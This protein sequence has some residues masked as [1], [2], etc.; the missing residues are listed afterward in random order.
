MNAV[1]FQ[2]RVHGLLRHLRQL[3]SVRHLD[4]DSTLVLLLQDDVR[5]LLVEPDTEAFKLAFDD[6]LVSQ[7]LL[8]VKHDQNE[9]A[10]ARH[11]DDLLTSTLAIFGSLDN[12]WQIE[13]LDLGA[14]IVE[15][16]WDAGQCCEFISGSLRVLSGQRCQESRL[17]YGREAYQ[18]VRHA[19]LQWT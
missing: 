11:T 13:Q 8:G 18:S 6:A 2:N 19:H 12:S 5:S 17:A 15:D 10:C 9:V 4:A 14:L 7:R 1:L 16:T 3:Y